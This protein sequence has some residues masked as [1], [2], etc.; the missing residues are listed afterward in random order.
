MKEPVN[1]HFVLA[2]GNYCH[3]LEDR[4]VIG[5]CDLPERLPEPV[6]KVNYLVLGLQIVAI[7]VLSFFL[8]MTV[9][10]MYF[11]VTFTLA[12]LLLVG[13]VTFFR[14]VKYSNTLA[15]MRDDIISV[16]YH[17]RSFGYDFFTVIYSGEGK[18]WVRRLTIYDS[19]QSLD[20]ALRVMKEEGY[21]KEAVKK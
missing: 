15:I 4:L 21:L 19:Q 10:A 6:N 18:A 13:T 17:K 3:F 7:I 16:Q 8:V 20:Q 12:C 1:P 5:R 14:S 9:I 2:D 11:I